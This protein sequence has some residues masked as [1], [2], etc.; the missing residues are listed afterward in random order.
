MSSDCGDLWVFGYGSLMWRPGF[1]YLERVPARLNGYHR[2]F[3]VWSHRYR[4]TPE[5]PGLVL[6]LDRGGSCRGIAYRVADDKRE[7]VLAY[8]HEREMITGVYAPRMLPVMPEGSD[9]RVAAQAYVVERDHAQYAAGL[10]PEER[11]A[12]I[13]QGHGT[14]GPGRDYLANTVGHLAELGLPDRRLSRLLAL[15]DGM[16]SGAL[17]IP[18]APAG[19]P[20]HP[21]NRPGVRPDTPI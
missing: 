21:A 13:I 2:D 4:G 8:L 19:P 1:D 5:K 15:V 17:P 18:P 9:R 10:T 3:C 20:A 14:A 16:L 11:A 12:L 7:A 6:G